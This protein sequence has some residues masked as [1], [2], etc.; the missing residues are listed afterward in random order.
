MIEES[1]I[2]DLI[3]NQIKFLKRF[4]KWFTFQ[5]LF[6]FLLP[7]LFGFSLMLFVLVGLYTLI[8]S[9]YWCVVPKKKRIRLLYYPYFLYTSILL[10]FF[11][12]GANVSIGYLFL[13]IYG[14][15]M[16]VLLK[17][18]RLNCKS[19][20]KRYTAILFAILSIL[21]VKS[22]LVKTNCS[23]HGTIENEKEEIL[24]RRNYLVNEIVT[25]PQKVMKLMPAGIGEQFQGEWALYTCSMLSASLVN[26]SSIYPETKK[27]NIHYIDKLIQIVMSPELRKY[28]MERWG[29][30]PLESLE[31]DNSHISYISHLAWMISGYKV[32]GGDKKYDD[33]FSDLCRT[34][35]RRIKQSECLCL[36]TY[37]NEPIYIPDMLVAI[38]ALQQYSQMN[39]R[40]Y[41]QTIKYWLDNA[42]TRW[43]DKETGLLVSLVTDKG[44]QIDGMPIKGSYSALNCSYLT[45]IDETFAK[46]QYQKFKKTFW[47]EGLISGIKEYYDYNCLFALDI[48]AGPIIGGLSPSGTA[49]ATGVVTYFLDTDLRNKILFTAEI[50]GNTIHWNG[51]RHYALAEI[52]IVGEAIMLAMRT[53]YKKVVTHNLSENYGK[54]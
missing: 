24:Q 29:E 8:F 38:V 14:A 39:N 22:I 2:D 20:F 13:P 37:P 47:K 18:F 32:L 3:I 48:D 5:S 35:N 9:V 10:L 11:L 7:Q 21:T 51:Q 44:T 28:D 16:Y 6:L 31:G 33:L 4:L 45:Y 40:M 52:A 46:E 19:R 54:S 27:E 17:A 25:N 50:A 1:E 12:L 15:T 30:D 41:S 23:S 26:I 42:K 53:N 36:P 43:T 49:F 34:M